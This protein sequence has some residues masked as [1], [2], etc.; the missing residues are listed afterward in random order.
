MRWDLY[1]SYKNAPSR[2]LRFPPLSQLFSVTPHINACLCVQG[3]ND[4][5]SKW[6]GE[7]GCEKRK[8][9][10]SRGKRDTTAAAQF[11]TSM[12]ISSRPEEC[13]DPDI[14]KR[15]A[16]TTT[17]PYTDS[18]DSDFAT[19]RDE[20]KIT[21][22]SSTNSA[23]SSG[24]DPS[25]RTPPR[26]ARTRTVVGS[27]SALA[28]VCSP[29]RRHAGLAGALSPRSPRVGG[30]PAQFKQH[31]S[32]AAEA[33]VESMLFSPQG[34]R[35]IDSMFLGVEIQTWG[36]SCTETLCPCT[37]HSGTERARVHWKEGEE[38][39]D[40]APSADEADTRGTSRKLS[41]HQDEE[42]FHFR[43]VGFARW[44]SR[45]DESQQR[46][47]HDKLGARQSSTGSQSPD[48]SPT[49]RFDKTHISLPAGDDVATVR[50]SPWNKTGKSDEMPRWSHTV[51]SDNLSKTPG[52]NSSFSHTR[53]THNT[54][55][56]ENIDA[57][58]SH[59]QTR[60]TEH[61]ASITEAINASLIEDAQSASIISEDG[62]VGQ[63]QT[64]RTIHEDGIGGGKHVHRRGRSTDDEFCILEDLDMADS[65]TGEIFVDRG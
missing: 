3:N 24:A 26:S 58:P 59:T 18:A 56:V 55:I 47:E 35:M 29:E 13:G 44:D 49:S 16:L 5:L 17:L 62:P 12:A 42:P 19:P 28:S 45:E 1:P 21:P 34:V 41:Q 60:R 57:S 11:G 27:S 50:D 2:E 43:E 8:G 46:L 53:C 22:R 25:P 40:R 32:M 51:W 9:R 23:V 33:T 14:L 48:L 39:R 6:R 54:S 61:N 4:P 10:E 31:V 38:D 64:P 65:E 20:T 52:G 63:I 15:V 36:D 30:L 7:K 37:A